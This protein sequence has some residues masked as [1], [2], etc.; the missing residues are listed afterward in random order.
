MRVHDSELEIPLPPSASDPS[1]PDFTI[2]QKAW[3]DA[4]SVFYAQPEDDQPMR[5]ALEMRIMGGSNVTMAPQ[6][7]N[8][9]TCSI[10]VLTVPNVETSSWAAYMQQIADKWTAYGP[11]VRPHWAKLWPPSM[12]G[13]PT[14]QYLAETAYASRLPQFK[15]DLQAIATAGGYTLADIRKLF[16]NATIGTIFASVFS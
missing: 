4:I 12:Y 7:G 6:Y 15:A 1:K 13:V 8:T 2:A 16:T 5:I 11:N 14:P 9:G 10:E 3:W